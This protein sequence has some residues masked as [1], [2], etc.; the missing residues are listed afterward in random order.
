MK[1]DGRPDGSSDRDLEMFVDIVMRRAFEKNTPKASSAIR[2]KPIAKLPQHSN[3]ISRVT[4]RLRQLLL[5]RSGTIAARHRHPYER[6][7]STI[8][9]ARPQR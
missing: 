1:L 8:V 6:L 9:A 3:A 5:S 4:E 7:P 2:P